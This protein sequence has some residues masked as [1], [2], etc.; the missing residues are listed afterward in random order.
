M[1]FTHPKVPAK[2]QL[3]KEFV[4]Y[5]GTLRYYFLIAG[6]LKRSHAN[7][8]IAKKVQAKLAKTRTIKTIVDMTERENTH[9]RPAAGLPA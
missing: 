9:M 1:G 6:C 2:E 5:K 8:F 7:F 4:F 3:L